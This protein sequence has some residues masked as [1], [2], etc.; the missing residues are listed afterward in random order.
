MAELISLVITL[1]VAKYVFSLM[2]DTKHSQYNIIGG[3][4][5]FP[6]RVVNTILD[7]VFEVILKFLGSLFGGSGKFFY[8]VFYPITF[9]FMWLFNFWRSPDISKNYWLNDYSKLKEVW[10]K[11]NDGITLGDG[12][13]TV[14]SSS[15]NT[16]II[17]PTGGG[18]TSGFILPQLLKMDRKSAKNQSVIVID[19]SS[20]IFESTSGYVS[21]IGMRVVKIDL[22]DIH[23][24][25]RW[26]PLEDMQLL[27]DDQLNNIAYQ[28][29][30]SGDI[31]NKFW[32]QQA[33][34]L[35]F[36]LLKVMSFQ[37]AKFHNLG[38][39]NQL[40]FEVSSSDGEEGI[41]ELVIRTQNQSLVSKYL[42]FV[43]SDSK[44]KSNTI[45]SATN[46][47]TWLSSDL[48]TILTESTFDMS[49]LRTIPTIVYIVVNEAKMG[50]YER[51]LGLFFQSL[52]EELLKTGRKETDLIVNLLLDEF[53]QLPTF[54][55]L[56]VFLSVSRKRKIWTSIYLQSV[57]QI[58]SRYS[59]SESETIVNGA[60]KNFVTFGSIDIDSAK[61]LQSRVGSDLITYNELMRLDKEFIAII[62]SEPFRA[63]L[64]GFY[65]DRKLL[66][67]SKIQEYEMDDMTRKIDYIDLP[68]MSQ[69]E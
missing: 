58:Y 57:S 51:L 60:I 38:V 27:S 11:S 2:F 54:K 43:E 1:V 3:I 41:M 61:D 31:A 36:T 10:S 47:L 66:K 46:S 55:I 13:L 65:D 17:S 20:E 37:A 9:P 50:Y 39:L 18:K 52:F 19:P 8:Y 59:K 15:R 62:N 44:M 12:N 25:D 53:A 69:S 56:P 40:L 26:N 14:E 33:Q 45:S 42:A 68:K 32:D 29:S 28:L 22:D 6:I 64:K 16:L 35:I 4:F 63:D 7:S 49:S 30:N 48:E 24:S 34:N 5:S 23:S 21:S 67:R